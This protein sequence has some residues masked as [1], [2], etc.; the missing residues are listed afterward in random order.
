MRWYCEDEN[1]LL[2]LLLGDK[3]I[4]WEQV[5]SYESKENFRWEAFLDGSWPNYQGEM[6]DEWKEKYLKHNQLDKDC[7]KA[8]WKKE[9][10]N[11]N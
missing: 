1:Y 3:S 8:I 11:N 6:S 9:I 4:T 5:E 2:R 10:I 7:L